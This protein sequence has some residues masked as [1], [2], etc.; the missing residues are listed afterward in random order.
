MTKSLVFLAA[1]ALALTACTSQDEVNSVLTSKNNVIKFENVVNKHSRADITT[2]GLE[3]F[4]VFGFYTMPGNDQ[5]AHQVFYNTPVNKV[6][7]AWDYS[8]GYGERYWIPGAKYYFYAYSCNNTKINQDVYTTTDFSMNMK[9]GISATDRVLEIDGYICNNDHQH[10]LIFASN[11]GATEGN[12]F[13]G[14]EGLEKDNSS[15]ALQFSHILSKVKAKFTTKFPTEYEIVISDLTIESINDQ[16]DYD[17][18]KGW[19]NYKLA[20]KPLSML[21][22]N[23]T[24]M[25]NNELVGEEGNKKQKSVETDQ[26]YVLPYTGKGLGAEGADMTYALQFTIDVY[27]GTDRVNKV[28]SKTL[29][30]EFTPAWGEGY[31]YVY[32]VDI[33]GTTT[34]MQVISFTTTVDEF[35]TPEDS[36]NDI[37]EFVVKDNG[38][39][40]PNNE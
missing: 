34:N 39:G 16:G 31:Q 38:V 12:A 20:S 33:N 19:H 4:Y 40:K 37:T 15:V 36:E 9:D 7:G 24:L 30:G 5:L 10:D 1:G 13:A 18:I 11:T 14:I 23:K 26:Y 17:P 22:E 25:I 2:E 21:E 35:G 32:N 6:D 29:T 8:S 27:I 3:H 28:M